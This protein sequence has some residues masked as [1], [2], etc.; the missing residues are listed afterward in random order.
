MFTRNRTFFIVYLIIFGFIYSG[1]SIF[2]SNYSGYYDGE[3]IFDE[4]MK[5]TLL[6]PDYTPPSYFSKDLLNFIDYHCMMNGVP[7]A[8]FYRLI[9]EESRWNTK[10]HN[11]SSN[12]YGLVQLNDKYIIYFVWKFGYEKDIDFKPRTNPYHNVMLGIRYF[13]SLVKETGSYRGAVISYNCGLTRYNSGSIPEK[14]LEYVD[15]I[16]PFDNWWL[17]VES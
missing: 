6:I 9:G 5:Q 15:R 8:L 12:D 14:T 3:V 16:I 7:K 11:R 4:D 10:A 17:L 13:A 1:S 2:P